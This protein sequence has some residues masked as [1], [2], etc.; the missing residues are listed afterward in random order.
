MK[1]PANPIKHLTNYF[2]FLVVEQEQNAQKFSLNL[3][4]WIHIH[5]TELKW[6]ENFMRKGK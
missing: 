5:L 1:T 2:K 6:H 4:K 3:A